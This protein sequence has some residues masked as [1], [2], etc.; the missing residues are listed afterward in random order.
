MSVLSAQISELQTA[1]AA[2]CNVWADAEDVKF[3]FWAS[4]RRSALPLALAW[5]CSGAP[6]AWGR[7]QA[8][9]LQQLFL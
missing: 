7:V 1:L 4:G 5:A 6:L 8:R 9:Y 3:A 2:S